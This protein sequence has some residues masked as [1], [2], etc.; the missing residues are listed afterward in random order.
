MELNH[1]V[2]NK[3]ILIIIL[4]LYLDTIKELDIKCKSTKLFGKLS[5]VNSAPSRLSKNII[6]YRQNLK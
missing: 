2:Y 3:F 6:I 1:R 5:I 4:S